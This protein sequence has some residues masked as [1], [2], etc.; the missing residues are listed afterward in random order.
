MNDCCQTMPVWVTRA[1]NPFTIL[2]SVTLAWLLVGAS[3]RCEVR[4]NILFAIADDWSYGHAGA[5]GCNWVSTPG[6]DR[7]AKEGLLFRR[8]YTPNAKC[9]P[10]RACLLTGRNSW[11]LRDACNHI[12]YFPPEFKTYAEALSENGYQVGVTGKGWGP[13]VA[14]DSEGKPRNM[15]GTPFNQRKSRPPAR[16]MSNN[17][18]AANFADFLN[19]VPSGKPWCFWYG[20]S[21]PHRAFEYGVGVSKGGKQLSDL[22]RVPGFW[23]DNEAT[24]H[25]MLDYGF[26]VEYFDA[27]LVQILREIEERGELA[28]TLVVVTSDHGMPF[29]RCK[30]QAYDF[31]NHVPLAIMWGKGIRQPGHVVE[32]YVSFIDLAPTFVDVA[33][34][35]WV[36]TGMKPSP[37]RS[38]RDLF[39][40]DQIGEHTNHRDHVLV[41][42]ERHDIG[43]PNDEGYPIRGIF[44]DDMLFLH[45]FKTTRWPAGNPET[46]YLNCDGSPT[47]TLVLESRKTETSSEFWQLC[48]GKR[49][50]DELYNVKTDPDC[51]VNLAGESGVQGDH[52]LPPGSTDRRAQSSR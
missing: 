44:K 11:Q 48:F 24:R 1:L 16:A 12:C 22:D 23:P 37:G 45:N 4:P 26:E 43:R 19:S 51:L 8:A 20:T 32:D 9:A 41:G 28:N 30:G 36:T 17:D 39:A 29:P 40:S 18:Y 15:A 3:A 25:D 14:A 50:S 31:S 42:K 33:G 38:L 13:G 52:A 34:L 10:S 21:E 49:A 46:G 7:V 47:K 2:A 27:H 5:Y 6:F 35:D